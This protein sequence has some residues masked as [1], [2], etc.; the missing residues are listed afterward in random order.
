MLSGWIWSPNTE[1]GFIY[2]MANTVWIAYCPIKNKIIVIVIKLEVPQPKY[3]L[4]A[5]F[6]YLFHHCS[7]NFAV[8][9][10]TTNE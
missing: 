1:A 3:H 7:K 6:I 9:V 5:I 10:Y 4:V 2:P 8:M